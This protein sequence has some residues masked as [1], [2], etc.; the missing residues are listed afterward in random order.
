MAK[1]AS[2]STV[3]DGSPARPFSLDDL[4]AVL[5]RRDKIPYGFFVSQALWDALVA[6][7]LKESGYYLAA[8]PQTF[9]GVRTAVDPS[10][11]ATAFDVAFN[12][13]AWTKRL[14][15]I[16]KAAR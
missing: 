9:N 8:I 3:G 16:R 14:A 15:E 2:T 4:S 6:R 11:P 13:E 1:M 10:L 12:E 5:M 7:F